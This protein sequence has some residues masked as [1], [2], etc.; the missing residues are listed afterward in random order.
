MEKHS[1]LQ[2]GKAPIFPVPKFSEQLGSQLSVFG[3]FFTPA[4]I[5]CCKGMFFFFFGG[6]GSLSVSI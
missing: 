2:P 5:V 6:G 4:R 3:W 1:F